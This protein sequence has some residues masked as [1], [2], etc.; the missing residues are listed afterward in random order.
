MYPQRINDISLYSTPKTKNCI[1]DNVDR[2]SC[3]FVYEPV[4]YHIENIETHFYK[5]KNMHEYVDQAQL[6][7][8]AISDIRVGI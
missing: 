4:K 6:S 5:K 8:L 7:N 1:L 2:R 3:W